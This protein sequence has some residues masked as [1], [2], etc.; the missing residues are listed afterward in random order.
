MVHRHL[1][2]SQEPGAGML[3]QISVSGQPG[4][5]APSIRPH[6]MVNWEVASALNRTDGHPRVVPKGAVWNQPGRM[7]VVECR[8][9]A[10]DLERAHTGSIT[11]VTQDNVEFGAGVDAGGGDAG[12][13]RH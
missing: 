13:D 4:Q 7:Q 2:P 5:T 12:G 9:I 10:P 6:D 1:I 11:P 3:R 8:V